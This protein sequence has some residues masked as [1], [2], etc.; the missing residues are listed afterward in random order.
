VSDSGLLCRFSGCDRLV[1]LCGLCDDH[2]EGKLERTYGEHVKD[3]ILV[4]SIVDSVPMTDPF[5]LSEWQRLHDYWERNERCLSVA[6]DEKWIS[7]LKKRERLCQELGIIL[8]YT[9][10]KKREERDFMS[11]YRAE[12]SAKWYVLTQLDGVF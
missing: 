8:M 7:D 5:L 12:S 6:K 9:V 4:H 2:W 1:K 3:S 11:I 10:R